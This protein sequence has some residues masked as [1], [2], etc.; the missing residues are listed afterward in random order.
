MLASSFSCLNCIPLSECA[1]ARSLLWS[2]S[3]SALQAAMGDSE[4]RLLDRSERNGR[5]R[6]LSRNSRSPSSRPQCRLS[7]LGQK[8]VHC[9][10]PCSRHTACPVRPELRVGRFALSVSVRCI[11]AFSRLYPI[12]FVPDVVV[13]GTVQN[14]APEGQE[15]EDE[16][17]EQASVRDNACAINA[18]GINCRSSEPRWCGNPSPS[19]PSALDEL[20]LCLRG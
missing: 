6:G 19:R 18:V 15:D 17:D 7:R 2:T 5:E 4:P 10:T 11:R 13:E 9:C 3:D 20:F 16:E 12:I 1:R 14:A 8:R